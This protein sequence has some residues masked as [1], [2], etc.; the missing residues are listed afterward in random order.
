MLRAYNMQKVYRQTK[1]KINR[2]SS[3]HQQHT[4]TTTMYVRGHEYTDR[5]LYVLN[6]VKWNEHALLIIVEVTSSL[7]NDITDFLSRNLCQIKFM[8]KQQLRTQRKSTLVNNP[9]R[10]TQKD[11]TKMQPHGQWPAAESSILEPR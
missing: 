7:S 2:C 5:S 8:Q 4:R 9:K 1:K 10:K 6:L 3:L 11:R